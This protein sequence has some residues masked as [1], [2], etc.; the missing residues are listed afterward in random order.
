VRWVDRRDKDASEHIS[1]FYEKSEQDV[2]RKFFYNR[3]EQD[4]SVRVEMNPIS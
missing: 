2:L 1:Y 4:Y 3:R